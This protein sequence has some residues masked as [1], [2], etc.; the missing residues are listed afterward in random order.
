M[1]MEIRQEINNV[2]A[3][4]SVRWFR[5]RISSLHWHDNVE[6]CQ[7]VSGSCRMLVDGVMIEAAEGDVIA[8]HERVIHRFMMVYGETKIRVCQF[9]L[10]VLLSGG[11]PMRFLKPH[12]RSREIAACT[13][14]EERLAALFLVMDQEQATRGDVNNPVMNALGQALFFLLLR[15]FEDP[16]N[17]IAANQERRLF[18]EVIAY[19]HAHYQEPLTETDIARNMGLSRGKLSAVFSKYAGTGLPAYLQQLRIHNA[20]RLFSEGYGVTEAALES[21]FQSVRT[22]NNV[23]R[24]VMNM[25]PSEYIQKN[26]RKGQ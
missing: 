20:N 24:R 9:S 17:T 15:H 10:K 2:R 22:F 6:I 5:N 11:E 21:G 1:G 23:Y 3:V 8:I 7:I 26:T 25:T 14:L 4:S 19:V 13:G 18:Y 12:I 16:S